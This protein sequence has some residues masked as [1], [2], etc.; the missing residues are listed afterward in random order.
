[1]VPVATR[2]GVVMS[3]NCD[4]SDVLHPDLDAWDLLRG[5]ARDA[6][7]KAIDRELGRL[8]AVRAEMITRTERCQAYADDGYQSSQQWV[9]ATGNMSFPSSRYQVQMARMLAT[10]PNVREALSKGSIG[11]DQVRVFVELWAN[12]RCRAQLPG[13]EALLLGCAVRFVLHEFK[14]VAARF[15]L[16]ADPDGAH[17]D[18]QESVKQRHAQYDTVGA[19]FRLIMEGDA[20]SG[21]MM[22]QVLDAHMEA[23]YLSDEA[24]RKEEFG[25]DAANHPL[26]RTNLQRMFDAVKT[27]FMKAAATTESTKQK[28]LVA[29]FTSPEDL[30]EALRRYFQ[31]HANPR[32]TDPADPAPSM[33]LRLCETQSGAPVS[34][35]DLAIAAIHGEIQRV[36]I[37]PRGHVI[38]LGRKTRLFRGP[39]REAVL[40]TG[41]RCTGPGCHTRHN[42]IQIDHI[43]PWELFGHT[44][45]D[46]G[47]PMCGHCNRQKHARKF[48]VKRDANGWH[49]FRPDG[50]EIA[51]RDE[52]PDN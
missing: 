7:V 26:A 39:A 29:L 42:G 31:E 36:I 9:R 37:D 43:R 8:Q 51:P 50:T 4:G 19:W 28:P 20:V 30:A 46:N 27:I 52:W 41:G 47:E 6:G 32:F 34:Y 5:A 14:E 35:R 16:G 17:R 22:K 12:P 24:A 15:K 23:E 25:D 11:P 33:R 48:S 18:H 21:D 49:F 2:V 45:Q 1:M 38:N 3:L 10:L 40:L 44:D 13:F